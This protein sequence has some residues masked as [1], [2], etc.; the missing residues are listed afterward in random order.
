[1]PP[2]HPGFEPP[3]LK[4][5]P[6]CDNPCTALGNWEGSPPQFRSALGR[7]LAQ[8]LELSPDFFEGDHA[9][10]KGIRKVDCILQGDFQTKTDCASPMPPLLHT[11]SSAIVM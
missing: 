4:Q 11:D 6:A 9:L 7:F 2:L 5:S 1:M 8:I 3:S 10:Y